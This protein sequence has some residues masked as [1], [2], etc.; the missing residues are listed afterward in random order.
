MTSEQNFLNMKCLNQKSHYS[1]GCLL[2][3]QSIFDSSQNSNTLLL[4][5][6]HFM[7]QNLTLLLTSFHCLKTFLKTQEIYHS[8]HQQHG[9]VTHSHLYLLSFHKQLKI[10]TAEAHL[11]QQ[12]SLLMPLKRKIRFPG[13][14]FICPPLNSYL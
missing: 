8:L 9:L 14:V 7:M 2:N 11:L 10:P 4:F 13:L 5:A 3:F 12:R 1:L 6:G